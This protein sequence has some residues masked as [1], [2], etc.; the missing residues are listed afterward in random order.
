MLFRSEFVQFF[1]IHE[2]WERYTSAVHQRSAPAWYF[3]PQLL[4]GFLP[5]LGLVPAMFSELR[6]EP[7]RGFRPLLFCAVWTV[8]IFGF[9]SLSGSKLP[10]Y[11]LPLFPALAFIAG[12][13]LQR[14]DT[15]SW[16]RLLVVM[17]LL[18]LAAL[19]ASP[20]IGRMPADEALRRYGGWISAACAL[21]V[22]GIGLAGWLQRRGLRLPSIAAYA[23]AFFGATT[24]G[25]L[26]HET[27]GRPN[28]GADL[29]PAI[30]SVLEPGM[31]IYSVRLL[32]H[33]LPFY[34][35]RTTVMVEA[36]DEL[37]FGVNQEPQKWLP[38][39]A[40]FSA[41]WTSGRPALALMAPRTHAELQAQ[42]VAMWTVARDARRVVVANFAPPSR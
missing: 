19:L 22:A 8:A 5:W 42:N 35:R 3:V 12:S 28:S 20:L 33:T 40:A 16:R 13:A 29:V 36:P 7:R 14:L 24:V 15:K 4:A 6:D 38:T 34:L 30:Q 32:D 41:A 39:L 23:L 10:G 2:H 26:G 21:A 37:E 11:I 31:P 25:L 9:F 27:L 18:C 17:G 1:F